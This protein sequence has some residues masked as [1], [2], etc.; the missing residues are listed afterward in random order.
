MYVEVASAI[1]LNNW[2]VYSKLGE[3]SQCA[4]YNRGDFAKRKEIKGS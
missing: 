3:V 1:F 2:S 4:N